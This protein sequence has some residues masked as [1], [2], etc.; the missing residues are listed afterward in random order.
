V[1]TSSLRAVAIYGYTSNKDGHIN[2]LRRIEGRCTTC[3]AE[4]RVA[5]TLPWRTCGSWVEITDWYEGSGAVVH[6]TWHLE[7]GTVHRFAALPAWL[8]E[9]MTV[10]PGDNPG[11]GIPPDAD[12]APFAPG[13]APAHPLR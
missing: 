4:L 13:R 9:D 5:A 7:T 6:F 8:A 3:T 11:P 12:N 1:R 2:R 10:Y